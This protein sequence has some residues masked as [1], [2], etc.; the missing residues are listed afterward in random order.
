MSKVG[1]HQVINVNTQTGREQRKVVLTLAMPTLSLIEF[2]QRFLSNVQQ[3]EAVLK[4]SLKDHA[5]LIVAVT[6]K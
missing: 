2:C 4:E 5:N 3:N 6:K 1:F